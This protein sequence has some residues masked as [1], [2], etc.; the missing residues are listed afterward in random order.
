MRNEAKYICCLG[1][2]IGFLSFFTVSLLMGKDVL[3]AVVKGSVGCL[4]FSLSA[5]GILQLILKSLAIEKRRAN[6]GAAG[7]F[8]SEVVPEEIAP[9]QKVDD[10]ENAT[11]KAVSEISPEAVEVAQA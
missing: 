7:D 11:A 2:F 9:P 6:E 10:D 8:S 4:F 3:D 5:R 1:G